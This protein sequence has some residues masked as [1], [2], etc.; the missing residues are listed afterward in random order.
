MRKVYVKLVLKNLTNEQ[1]EARIRNY[2]EWL[3]NWDVFDRVI[4]G[5]KSWISAYDPETQYRSREWKTL[6]EPRT[7]IVRMS[8]SQTKATIVTFFDCR[9]IILKR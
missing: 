5:A 9:S 1:K 8:K 3:E 7:K 6:E 2:T 4:I